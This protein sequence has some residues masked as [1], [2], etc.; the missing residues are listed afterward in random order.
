M[1]RIIVAG[2][3][4]ASKT[5]V[6]RAL[7]SCE[8]IG[9]AS[10]IVSGTARGADQYGED[11]AKEHA[12]DIQHYP[13]DWKKHGKKAGPLRNEEMAKNAEGLIAVWDGQSR[14][15][16]SMIELASKYGLRICVYRVDTNMIETYE[17]TDDVAHRWEELEE[18]AAVL[19]YGSG[20]SREKAEREALN[21]MVSK[22]DVTE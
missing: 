2:C 9:F 13:A 8:W 14:G 12:I 18:R 20:L 6:N 17:A 22:I 11:W 15:T 16:K 10:A 1:M 21:M 5:D 3:R 7:S 4:N 19:E